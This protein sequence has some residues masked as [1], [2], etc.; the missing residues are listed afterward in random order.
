VAVHDIGLEINHRTLIKPRRDQIARV[1]ITRRADLGDVVGCVLVGR[2]PR[3][4]RHRC[5]SGVGELELFFVGAIEKTLQHFKA[6]I[7]ELQLGRQVRSVDKK[8]QVIPVDQFGIPLISPGFSVEM[9]AK[10]NVRP[11]L[12]VNASRSLPDFAGAVKKNFALPAHGL[13]SQ[14]IVGAVEFLRRVLIS[15]GP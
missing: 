5:R 9:Q 10:N 8:V 13:F 6:N 14:R 7:I 12:R 15:S 2:Q 1:N 11:Q 3:P 4:F